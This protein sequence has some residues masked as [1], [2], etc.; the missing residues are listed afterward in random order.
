M[1][2]DLAGG[3]RGP[4]HPRPLAPRHATS[5]PRL[6]CGHRAAG[7]RR[8]R[9][10]DGDEGEPA[11]ALLDATRRPSRRDGA[12]SK[13]EP[14]TAPLTKLCTTVKSC[15][16]RPLR[17]LRAAGRKARAGMW[18]TRAGEQRVD[19]V[20]GE[21]RL[22]QTLVFPIDCVGRRSSH[23]SRPRPPLD[24][25]PR[26]A[27]PAETAA[28]PD[29]GTRRRRRVSV[30]GTSPSTR[31]ARAHPVAPTLPDAA[32][33]GGGFFGM[34]LFC[35]KTVCADCRRVCRVEPRDVQGVHRHERARDAS[36]RRAG[37]GV[38]HDL[39]APPL[40]ASPSPRR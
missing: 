20:L 3:V 13:R 18:P 28:A 26:C 15:A 32:A 14:K 9:R 39:V 11:I 1:A 29:A 17:G 33:G 7:G 21:Q 35:N 6:P 36:A 10:H 34:F 25:I 12:L 22:L 37:P 31:C 38:T 24:C 19:R 30:S 2:K 4:R 16:H 40:H 8:G 27:P 23:T 5:A